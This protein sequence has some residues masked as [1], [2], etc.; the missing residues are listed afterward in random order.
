M[1][2]G[3]T[4]PGRVSVGICQPFLV[5]NRGAAGGSRGAAFGAAR[6]GGAICCICP[7]E[8]QGNVRVAGNGP[9]PG[10]ASPTV[11]WRRPARAVVRDGPKVAARL[12][13]PDRHV[14]RSAIFVLV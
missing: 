8:N 9:G 11:D 5:P 3:T 6:A 1:A 4:D 12:S 13:R 7:V 10:T 2:F 14:R